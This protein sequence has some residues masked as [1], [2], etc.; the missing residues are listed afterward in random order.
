MNQHPYR[1][2][3]LVTRRDGPVKSVIDLKGH[4]CAVPKYSREHCDLFVHRLCQE[5]GQNVT[6]FFAGVLR[7]PTVEN[8]LDDIVDGL[9]PA[10]VVDG[11]GLQAY[12]RRKPARFA[13][14]Q[15]LRT[16]ELFP[17]SVIAYRSGALDRVIFERCRKGLLDA[18]KHIKGRL[19]MM[20]WRA[21]AFG[22]VPPDF[23][24]KLTAVGRAYRAP[25]H[26]LPQV[27]ESHAS[28]SSER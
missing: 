21:T 11:V 7:P 26:R 6:E 14:L 24:E 20:L 8:A 17:D 23:E 13:K 22:P 18:D 19:L 5:R 25:P 1:Q 15:Q 16:S 3:H 28:P 4:I 9:L 10:A 2:A 27:R 12:Q